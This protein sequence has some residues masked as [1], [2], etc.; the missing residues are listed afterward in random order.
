METACVLSDAQRQV[1]LYDAVCPTPELAHAVTA[2]GCS[3]GV[4]V[5]AS[6][7]PPEDNGYKV[8]DSDGAQILPEPAA[9]IASA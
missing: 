2:L 5:T 7:N 1:Y 8:Y 9:L 3:A 6:H 4:M